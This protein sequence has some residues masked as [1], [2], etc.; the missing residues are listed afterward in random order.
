[1]D[2][3]QRRQRFERNLAGLIVIGALMVVVL[4]SSLPALIGH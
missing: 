1:M 3:Q 2:L 4:F